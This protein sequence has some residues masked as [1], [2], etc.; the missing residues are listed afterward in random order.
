MR[1]QILIL[2]ALLFTL[3]SV[4]CKDETPDQPGD[5]GDACILAAAGTPEGCAV[6]LECFGG[7]CE[8][9]CVSNDDCQP[10]EGWRHE[11][12]AGGCQIFCDENRMCP[13][14]LGVPLECGVDFCEA[15]DEGKSK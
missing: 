6:G 3:A 2:P 10:V 1:T 5:F 8:E 14:T 13:Q 11:C 9:S 12:V 7:Y 15:K 4:Q